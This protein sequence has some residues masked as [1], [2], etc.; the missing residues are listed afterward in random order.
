MQIIILVVL[1]VLLLLWLR[2][3][4]PA[5]DRTELIMAMIGTLST[6][7]V[8]ICGLILLAN[9]NGSEGFRFALASCCSQETRTLA[10]HMKCVLGKHVCF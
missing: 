6:L 4:R 1:N 3:I 7:G 2:L 10:G 5:G 9:P 8:Y